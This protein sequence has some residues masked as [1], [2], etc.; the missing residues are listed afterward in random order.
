MNEPDSITIEGIFASPRST[1]F[2]GVPFGREWTYRG[3]HNALLAWTKTTCIDVEAP[4]SRC[5]W[6]A[7]GKAAVTPPSLPVVP[8]VMPVAR[9]LPAVLP[10]AATVP[11]AAAMRRRR[12][13]LATGLSIG[14]FGII[15]WLVVAHTPT[16][17]VTTSV[18]VVSGTTAGDSVRPSI[19]A[20]GDIE[21]S[22]NRL[23]AATPT[24]NVPQ[25][26][27][28]ASPERIAGVTSS[29]TTPLSQHDATRT[30]AGANSAGSRE[31]FR[32]ERLVVARAT[33]GPA[34][35]KSAVAPA[36]RVV[37]RVAPSLDPEDATSHFSM[38]TMLEESIEIFDD[39]RRQTASTTQPAAA[40]ANPSRGSGS[41][42]T[43]RL[44]HQRLTDAPDA[45]TRSSFKDEAR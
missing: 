19:P 22:H 18:Q 41:D 16:S 14:G 36:P 21:Q 7:P 5:N 45:F 17:H 9:V 33:S 24:A 28:P 11:T 42:W 23:A 34:I 40:Y 37:A 13:I 27:P 26:V 35:R 29:S 2:D 10:A 30:E 39:A 4:H 32:S 8:P 12:A 25:T 20:P 15:G 38:S 3:M 43:T 31:K 44:A 6:T 1:L